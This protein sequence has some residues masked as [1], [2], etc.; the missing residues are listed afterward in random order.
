MAAAWGSGE[1][2]DRRTCP[3]QA[4]LPKMIGP[5]G[6]SIEGM[7]E[8]ALVSPARREATLYGPWPSLSEGAGWDETGSAYREVSEHVPSEVN[9]GSAHVSALGNLLDFALRLSVLDAVPGV[10]KV[11]REMR[12]DLRG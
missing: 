1:G 12:N 6:I 10:G 4:H 8:S 7:L 5:P 3:I 9:L 2:E 11:Q